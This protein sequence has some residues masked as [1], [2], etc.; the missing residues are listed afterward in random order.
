MEKKTKKEIPIPKF[1]HDEV[2]Q[3]DIDQIKIQRGPGIIRTG[4]AATSQ[5]AQPTKSCSLSRFNP[6]PFEVNSLAGRYRSQF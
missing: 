2:S 4:S 1:E 6:Y 5:K 3:S